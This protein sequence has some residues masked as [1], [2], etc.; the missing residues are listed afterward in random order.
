M[1]IAQIA[2]GLTLSFDKPG[3]PPR[4]AVNDRGMPLG[5]MARLYLFEN[6]SNGVSMTTF[7]DAL[8][9]ANATIKLG[10]NPT[11][12]SYGAQITDTDGLVLD[13][14]LIFP[15]SGAVVMAIQHTVT[16]PTN[17]FLGLAAPSSNNFPATKGGNFGNAGAPYP[18]IWVD[19]GSGQQDTFGL[20]D[21]AGDE[22]GENVRPHISTTKGAGS[23]WNVIAWR[24]NGTYGLTD[25]CTLYRWR[26]ASVYESVMIPNTSTGLSK[27]GLGWCG[28]GPL[29]TDAD[30]VGYWAALSG[31]PTVCFGLWPWGV[32]RPA[33]GRIGLAAILNSFPDDSEL[34][35]IMLRSAEVMIGRSVFPVGYPGVG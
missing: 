29:D 34:K 3:L 9:L 31:S 10:A 30:M 1:S 8:G 19:S 4:R 25:L 17:Q 5:K 12:Q 35:E 32:L 2:K 22:F 33:T 20:L 24:W 23:S 21:H 7:T 6:G 27:G 14:G 13:S 15:A 18:N 28:R 26:D 16:V 11:K